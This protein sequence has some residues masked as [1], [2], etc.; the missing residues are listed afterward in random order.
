MAWP[1]TPSHTMRALNNRILRLNPDGVA[2]RNVRGLAHNRQCVFPAVASLEERLDLLP[3]TDNYWFSRIRS[4]ADSLINSDF[5]DLTVQ[6]H[7]LAGRLA[8]RKFQLKN[9]KSP[10]PAALHL[11]IHHF[12]SQNVGRL[13]PPRHSL[14]R[15]ST[16][17]SARRLEAARPCE[18]WESASP[19]AFMGT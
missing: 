10:L 1:L 3:R 15:I 12:L 11:A 4:V 5:A 8:V 13:S 2:V 9:N 14:N 18:R 16:C 17:M 6:E 19:S 7:A